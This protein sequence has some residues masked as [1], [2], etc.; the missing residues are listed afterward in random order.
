MELSQGATHL[1]TL[2]TLEPLQPLGGMEQQQAAE[3]LK[4]GHT[5][6]WVLVCW[7]KR[8]LLQTRGFHP[9]YSYRGLASGSQIQRSS[10]L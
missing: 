3:Q 8:K 1:E 9:E 7:E 10:G 5:Q 2:V 6:P 4:A